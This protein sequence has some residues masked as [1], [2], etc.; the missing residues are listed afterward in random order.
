MS[1][2]ALDTTVVLE[3]VLIKGD[4]SPARVGGTSIE[5]TAATPAAP[6]ETRGH[7]V[8]MWTVC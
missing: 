5:R 1:C 4:P 7:A 2:D 3:M 6:L 8:A